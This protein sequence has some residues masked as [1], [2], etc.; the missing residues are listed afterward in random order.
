M[1][2][3]SKIIAVLDDLIKRENFLKICPK[4]KLIGNGEILGYD[5][6]FKGSTYYA[7][8]TLT[9]CQSPTCSVPVLVWQ[10]DNDNDFATLIELKHTVGFGHYHTKKIAMSN[11]T[12][13][14]AKI[15]FMNTTGLSNGIPSVQYFNDMIDGYN[16]NGLNIAYLRSRLNVAKMVADKPP[17]I[18]NPK[19]IF[20]EDREY[21]DY[22]FKPNKLYDYMG[23]YAGDYNPNDDF[24][25]KYD[26]ARD[27]AE[28][29][30]IYGVKK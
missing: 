26:D 19:D 18:P 3:D 30:I 25:D 29:Y 9:Y 6:I 1:N 5:L 12:T 8:A 27:P 20:L 14:D 23:S 2:M 13:I 15:Y 17:A 10:I 28:S 22:G 16:E 7:S 24:V 11:G 21:E 4:A